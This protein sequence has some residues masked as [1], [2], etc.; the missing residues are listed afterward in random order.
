VGGKAARERGP[1]SGFLHSR[2]PSRPRSA[3][4]SS[5]PLAPRANR[6]PAA[7]VRSDGAA[8]RRRED[9]IVGGRI[10]VAVLS[11]LPPERRLAGAAHLLRA[12]RSLGARTAPAPRL[13]GANNACGEGGSGGVPGVVTA[14]RCRAVRN[15]C[16]PLQLNGEDVREFRAAQL[17]CAGLLKISRF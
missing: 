14:T 7:V 13:F 4:R 12:R 1:R 11:A 17:Y 16:G 5:V 10:S 6:A 8:V 9:N 2:P 3:F 15:W